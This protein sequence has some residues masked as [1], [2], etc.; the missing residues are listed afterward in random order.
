[1]S[2]YLARSASD[3]TDAWPL[4]YV[5]DTHTGI[6]ATV[7][8]FPETRGFMPFLPRYEAETLAERAN[9]TPSTPPPVQTL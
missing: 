1:M 2:R 9:A 3:K 7:A 5:E 4:W 8:L 6:N